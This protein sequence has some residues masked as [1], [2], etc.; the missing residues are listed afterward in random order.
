MSDTPPPLR[1]RLPEAIR[2]KAH[3]YGFHALLRLFEAR[4]RDRPRLG[5]SRRPSED[6]IRL[7]PR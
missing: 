5:R 6:A 2:T 3:V 4:N 7:G 1:S